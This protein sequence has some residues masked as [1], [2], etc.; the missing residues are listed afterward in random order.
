MTV[1]EN[2][3]VG[4][5]CRTRSGL[6][7]SSLRLPRQRAEERAIA[8]TALQRLEYVGLAD[9][10]DVPVSA[11][12][13]GRRRMVELARALATDPRLLLLDEPASGLNTRETDELAELIGR[14][15]DSGVTVLLVEHDM[16]LVMDIA[17][18]ILVLHYGKPIA[19]GE[20]S[21]VRNDEKVVSV[22]LGGDFSG[23]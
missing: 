4:R 12:P 7:A 14:I 6:V 16:S 23:A 1:L 13:F 9:A 11:L 8:E 10:A 2:V 5:H 17:D 3:M 20:P 15:R 18:D 21:A 19:E 22:Y